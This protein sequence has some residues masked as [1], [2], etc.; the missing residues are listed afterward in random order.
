[1]AL[2]VGLALG[3]ASLGATEPPAAGATGYAT[4]CLVCHGPDLRGVDG[5]GVDLTASAFVGRLAAPALAGFLAQGRLPDAPDSVAGRPMPGFAWLD[6]A[7][8]AVIAAYVK[9][10]HGG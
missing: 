6:R 3:A 5:L 9:A 7:E 1:M 10:R 8:L 4:H 2:G